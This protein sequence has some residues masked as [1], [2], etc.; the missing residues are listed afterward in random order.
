MRRGSAVAMGVAMTSRTNPDERG[1]REA[2]T[3]RG[4]AR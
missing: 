1:K 3:Q 4:I 2:V